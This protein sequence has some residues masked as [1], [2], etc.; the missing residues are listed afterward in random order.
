MRPTCLYLLLVH[1]SLGGTYYIHTGSYIASF[2]QSLFKHA[3]HT[4]PYALV[5]YAYISGLCVVC[6]DC[7]VT[8]YPDQGITFTLLIQHIYL[9]PV[10]LIPSSKGGSI[11][12]D[13]SILAAYATSYVPCMCHIAF[14]LSREDHHSLAALI[15]PLYTAL[16][17]LHTRLVLIPGY[18]LRHRPTTAGER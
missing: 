2:V 9:F 6:T 8:R 16:A 7:T 3:A 11:L 15:L 5:Y 1:I 17:I 12:Y 10:T 4:V 18:L 14:A 13:W